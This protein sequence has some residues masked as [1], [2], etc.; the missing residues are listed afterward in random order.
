[1]GLVRYLFDTFNKYFNLIYIF[2]KQLI[3]RYKNSIPVNRQWEIITWIKTQRRVSQYPHKYR[4]MLPIT[5]TK[6]CIPVGSG[7]T[8]R[9][10]K[11]YVGMESYVNLFSAPLLYKCTLS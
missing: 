2:T 4:Q 5:Q 1:M 8:E 6:G 3:I 10:L 11:R 7:G 9:P